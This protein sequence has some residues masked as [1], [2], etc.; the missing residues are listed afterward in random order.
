M[1]FV[2]AIAGLL[3][4]YVAGAGFGA[5]AVAALSSN[6]HDKSLEIVMTAA[7]VTG[8][9]GAVVGCI[10]GLLFRRGASRSETSQPG[11]GEPL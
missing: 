6:M 2:R 9:I 11:P 7:F 10:V 3:L 4:G 5:L 1:R 8:P